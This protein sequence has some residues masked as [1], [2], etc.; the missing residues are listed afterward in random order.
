MPLRH[1]H[2][3]PLYL[4][5]AITLVVVSDAS[6]WFS[7]DFGEAKNQ[8][9]YVHYGQMGRNGFFGPYDVDNST[10]PGA[11]ANLNSW[12]GNSP[13]VAQITSGSN[14][15]TGQIS[16]NVDPRLGNEWIRLK[17]RYNINLYQT[18][19]SKGA[20]NPMSSSFLTMWSLEVDLPIFRVGYGKRRFQEGL[21]LQ[22]DF[23]RTWE[24]LVIERDFIVPDFLGE[25]VARGLLPRK[26]L[27]Y[28]N[29]LAWGR[30][31][32]ELDCDQEDPSPCDESWP[33]MRCSYA[34]GAIYPATLKL[35]VG[36]LPWQGVT[37]AFLNTP[38]VFPV[39]PYNVNDL[40]A[41]VEQ[42]WLAYLLYTSA[43]LTAGIGTIRTVLRAGPE[44]LT[45]NLF[46]IVN[47]ERISDSIRRNH[48]P[49]QE[50]YLTEGWAFIS[51]NN[52]S[53]FLNAE[54]DWYNRIFRTLGTYD[55]QIWTP[56]GPA[57]PLDP[58]SGVSLFA[59]RYIESWRFL[60][61]AG[62]FFGPF[63]FKSL[64]A[65]MPG[66]DR[67]HGIVIDRQPFVQFLE[68]QGISVFDPYSVH[69]N[70]LFSGGVAAPQHISAATVF[71]MKADYMLASNLL[72]Y[73]SFLKAM[74]NAHGYGLGYV[75]PSVQGIDDNFGTVN[76][77]V[78]GTFVSSAPS[79]PNN[80]LGWEVTAGLTWE[81]AAGNVIDARFSYWQPGKWFNY[82]CI[83]RSV[84]IWD[85]PAPANNWGVNSERTIDPVFGIEIRLSASY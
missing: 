85:V 42:N 30:Y 39:V 48:T 22:F 83:D 23:N 75:R 47:N 6:A 84:P 32:T 64:F 50:L 11:Y 81:L 68:Q 76:Y 36:V 3:L 24:Y 53:V 41:G 40:S 78:R 80:D 57:S 71:G 35:G 60:S 54:L 33:K 66:Q 4:V 43:D 14:A 28:F 10:T 72:V 29:P 63:S 37:T 59:P 26:I 44:L 18:G 2:V 19:I 5:F 12:I 16:V 13:D 38:F 46:I 15:A 21:G 65:Y 9:G 7:F 20:F 17:G 73:G 82:A 56:L 27:S 49:T 79:I 45:N 55:G 67:R 34:G 62:L 51:Y 52:G 70:Y 74:R 31:K 77:G 61:E 8:W 25:L 58:E 1:P 69:L